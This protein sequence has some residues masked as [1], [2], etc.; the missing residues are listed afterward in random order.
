M[1]KILLIIIGCFLFSTNT[2]YSQTIAFDKD[3]LQAVNVS[4]SLEQLMGRQVVKVIKDSAVKTFDQPTFVKIDGVDFKN[5][6]IEVNVLSRLLSTA[7][8]TAR[9]FI[10]VAF[11]INDSNSKFEGIY[12]RP[13]NGRADD[14]LRR[15][16]SI[17]YFSYPGYDFEKSRKE[18][19]GLYESYAD[20]GLNEWI[21]LKIEVKDDKAKLFINYNR[22]PSLIVNDLKQG[23]NLSGSIGLW[24]DVGTEGFFSDLKIMK[25][26]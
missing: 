25:N 6:I 4:L 7:P 13:T 12:I 11:R 23:A 18:A 8:E 22:Q 16:H 17:Q 15:N 5:G 3:K 21:N 9:G 1:K 10:G 19:P 2:L 20:M 24:V 14:Q 26:E